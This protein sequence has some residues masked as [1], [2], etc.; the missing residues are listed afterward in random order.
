MADFANSAF[1]VGVFSSNR[2]NFLRNCLAEWRDPNTFAV[3]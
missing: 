1:G 3:V 2:N